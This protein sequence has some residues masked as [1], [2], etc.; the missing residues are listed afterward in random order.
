MVTMVMKMTVKGDD[1]DDDDDDDGRG[2]D[3]QVG[4]MLDNGDLL[5]L[6]EMDEEF[7]EEFA[8]F[9]ASGKFEVMGNTY[10]KKELG[11]GILQE[12][13][14]IELNTRD[15]S[16]NVEHGI[17]NIILVFEAMGVN[18][19]NKMLSIDRKIRKESMSS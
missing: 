1:D 19:L 17:I 13:G 10:V 12:L 9:L 3:G 5:L 2:N 4:D 11:K 14:A 18:E 15:F 6:L 8:L 16:R 7:W